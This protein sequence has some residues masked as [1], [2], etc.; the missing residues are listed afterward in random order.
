MLQLGLVLVDL[1]RDINLLGEAV[2]LSLFPALSSFAAWSGGTWRV[3]LARPFVPVDGLPVSSDHRRGTFEVREL[4]GQALGDVLE[5]KGVAAVYQKQTL[6]LGAQSSPLQKPVPTGLA[7]IHQGH[8]DP[9]GFKIPFGTSVPIAEGFQSFAWLPLNLLKVGQVRALLEQLFLLHG[10]AERLQ[11]KIYPLLGVD[12]LDGGVFQLRLR[13]PGQAGVKQQS[14]FPG[15]HIGRHL[16]PP[17]SHLL[18]E[19]AISTEV[20]LLVLPG[21]RG[22]RGPA[23]PSH[24]PSRSHQGVPAGRGRRGGRRLRSHDLLVG[25]LGL[26]WLTCC[27]A[28]CDRPCRP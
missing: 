8:F 20:R 22:W 5:G 26:G 4:H 27:Q 12:G 9:D 7:I 19:L 3:S 18:G 11:D 24:T 16:D 28:L 6:V 23:S 1:V 14:S 2:G 15:C 13:L 10:L 17:K 25:E 21:W